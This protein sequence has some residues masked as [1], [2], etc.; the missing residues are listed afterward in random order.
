MIQLYENLQER[1]GG[2][3]KA[4][5]LPMPHRAHSP[6]YSPTHVQKTYFPKGGQKNPHTHNSKVLRSEDSR[7]GM[8]LALL[9]GGE[10]MGEK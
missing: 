3:G 9:A 5:R 10:S 1:E 8:Y 6:R 7:K 4:Q 2:W